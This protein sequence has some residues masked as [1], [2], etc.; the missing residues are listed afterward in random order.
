M[1]PRAI[2]VF[3]ITL[4]LIRVSGMRT[5]GRKSAFDVCIMILLGAVLS[6]AITGN[7]PFWPTVIAAAALVS[8][9]RLLAHVARTHRWLEWVLK[10][11]H[12]VLCEDGVVNEAMMKRCG[13][14]QADLRAGLRA[15]ANTDDL[16]A[17]HR[18]ISE[19]NGDITAVK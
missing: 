1:V 13:L 17:V 12:E 15:A 4:L 19:S 6:R 5:V 2:A 7:S 18:V 9:K 8:I 10:G 16:A 14:S 11:E 3:F